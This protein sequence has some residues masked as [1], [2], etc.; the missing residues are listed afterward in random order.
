[1]TTLLLLRFFLK[2]K[3]SIKIA[4]QSKYLFLVLIAMLVSFS[5]TPQV[6]ADFTTISSTTGCGSLVVEFQD[7]S[8][9]NPTAWLWDFG[10]GNTSTLENPIA[11]YAIPGLYDVEL[12]V[13]DGLTNDIKTISSYVKVHEQPT[14]DLQVNSL[15]TGC[16]PLATDFLDVSISSTPVTTWQWDFGDGSSSNLQNPN[17]NYETDGLFSVSL[18]IVDANGCQSLATEVDLIEV[19]KVPIADFEADITFSCNSSETI[20]FTNNSL[21]GS[22]YL[23]DFGDGTTS[24]L[25]NP[26]HTFNSGTFTVTLCA[27]E[28][29]CIDTLVLIDLIKV[30]AS[31]TPDFNVSTNSGCEGLN[32]SFTDVT[33]N[34]PNAWLWDFGNGITSNLQNPTHEYL[35][36]GIFDISLTTTISGQCETTLTFPA[37]IEILEKPLINFSADTTYACSFPFSVDF[38]DNTLNA[39]TWS[40][41]F[42]NGITSN[43]SN[44]S[45][46]YG[47]YGS[48]DVSLTV[49]NSDGCTATQL[50]NNLIDVEKILIDITSDNIEVCIPFDVNFTDLTSSIRPLVDWNWNFGDGNFS[51]SQNPTH[52]YGVGGTFDVSLLVFNDYGCLASIVFP[53]QITANEKPVVNFVASP[54]VSCAGENISFNDLS[55]LGAN[56]WEWIFGDGSSSNLQNP[57]YQYELTGVYDVS[58]ITGMNNCKDTLSMP[59]FIEIIE[60]T[61]IFEEIY[62]CDDPFKV[63]FVNLSI[64]ADDVLWDFGDGTTSTLVS[65]IHSFLSAGVHNVSLTVSNTLTGCSHL[66]V[67]QIK[68]TQPEA[69]FDYLINSANNY[70]DSVG[71]VPKTVYIDNQSQDWSYY[72]V[73]WSDGYVGYGRE[74]HKFTT[75]GDFD[76][77]LIITDIHGCKD[78]LVRNNMYHMHDVDVDFGIANV[79]G[80]DSMLVDFV[81]LTSPVSS[82][83]WVFGD[84]GT[85]N[86][87]NPQYIYYNEGFYD[88]TV[89]AESAMGCK[90]TLTRVEYIQFQY[91]TADL[92]SN[93]QGICPGDEVQFS[94]LSDGIAVEIVWNFGDGTQSS[95]FS[96]SHEY[97][98]NGN[99]DVSLL[100]TDSFGCS[101]VLSLNNYIEVLAPIASFSTSGLSSN[102]PPLISDFSNNSSADAVIFN[103][104]FGDGE[105]SVVESPSHLFATSG[106]FDVSLIVENSL[107]CKDTLVQN[108][109]INIAGPT[110]TFTMSDSVIC[111]DEVVAFNPT[112]INANS[113]LW[114]FGNGVLSTDSFPTNTYYFGGEFIPLLIIENSSGCQFTVPNNDTLVV[115]EIIVDAGVD[116]EICEGEQIQLNAIGNALAFIWIGSSISN[117]LIANPLANP[118]LD[119]LYVVENS[120]G[121]CSATDSVNITV[122]NDVPSASF[123]TDKHCEGDTL[124]FTANSG[125]AT[126]N[127]DYNW[128]LGLNGQVVSSQL[129]LGDN[130]ITLVIENLENSCVDTLV[131]NIEIFPLP[132][133][134][135]NAT[136]VCD[137]DPVVFSNQS[138]LNTVST[139][140]DFA[141]GLGSSTNSSPIYTYGAPGMYNVILDVV[142]DK[143]CVNSIVKDVYVNELPN[144]DFT[145]EESC[146]GNPTIFTDLSTVLTSN[147]NSILFDFGNGNTSNDSISSFVFLNSGVHDVNLTAITKDGCESSIVK[148]INVFELPNIDFTSS[149]FCFGE[150]THFSDFS[151]V[152]N[153]TIIDWLWDF[154]NAS[155]VTNTQHPSYI[156]ANSGVF[157]VS[158]TSI[159]DK[160]CVSTKKEE[161]VIYELPSSNFTINNSVCLNEEF[162]IT[163]LSEGNGT[164]IVQWLYDFNDGYISDKQN[165]SHAY[166]YV[167]NFNVSLEVISDIGC[168]N[169]TSI[170]VEVHSL[171]IANFQA[172]TLH[173]PETEAEIKFYNNS[174]GAT[175]LFWDFD[176]GMTSSLENPIIEFNNI[177]N[178]NVLFIAVSEFGCEDEMIKQVYIHPEY[179]IFV[180]TAFTP[181]G[182]GLNDIF[183][184]KGTGITEFEM[185][186]FDRWGGLVFESSSV[187]YGWN[188]KNVAGEIVNNGTYLYHVA[189]YDHNGRLWVYNGELNLMR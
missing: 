71:C 139:E 99:Y 52:T 183:E 53:N 100:V 182:D 188:G 106:V 79:L 184:A 177:G 77:T 14:A 132:T 145:I 76:V 7:V 178:Y 57:N 155:A 142:S 122:H 8:T 20:A 107:G 2:N 1:M 110:G 69:Q 117:N 156:F 167:N 25:E 27:K 147:I 84:G 131:Q 38:I 23:W 148:S 146:L 160:G 103:W 154:D 48:Y 174:V 102:C 49:T 143:G 16:V 151:S 123:T 159:S 64:G 153:G 44:P 121:L 108:G 112:V 17:Y 73:L 115:R 134:N 141:D 133:A 26:T 125:L 187:D 55:S 105:S 75:A 113:F 5:A 163:D 152:D 157:N 114:D 56:N 34:N 86:V 21:N 41:D 91:P 40:W 24:N 101:D 171:P 72:K 36:S 138:S 62:N 104:M 59:A 124:V 175:K 136:T 165:P 80:C 39:I 87:N 83:D 42:G 92:S 82:V 61:A 13:N 29:S 144:A 116:F 128:S 129:V 12:K 31:L 98:S 70:D 172:S 33:S 96:P 179:T 161:V 9:G 65:P 32:V 50:E 81:D 68:V 135:F 149:Q 97:L 10:N 181:D 47:N 89:F 78:T 93:I 150:A 45:V 60:P 15:A 43:I 162:E 46:S 63:E 51:N 127:V 67:K 140:Y 19:N 35:A 90:D 85:S 28:G 95:I 22:V 130:A 94:N 111:K 54:V 164:E 158:L 88:V 166:S 74:D 126:L 189:L 30:G 6:T 185:Q 66:F 4:Q 58:L 170:N 180:P 176:N 11:I 3:L 168:K 173:A 169:D 119:V 109:L 18:S 120:D 137:G 186:V 37:E 118:V